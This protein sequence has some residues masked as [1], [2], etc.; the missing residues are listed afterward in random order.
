[1]TWGSIKSRVLQTLL[2]PILLVQGNMVRKQA[3]QLPEAKG[4]RRGFCGSGEDLSIIFLGDSSACGVG[5]DHLDDA[6][7]GSLLDL[8]KDEYSC[9]WSIL[10]KSKIITRDLIKII[11]N[12]A[13]IKIDVAVVCIG[14][15]D[16]TAGKHAESWMLELSEL[17]SLLTEKFAAK[18][19]IFSGIPPVRHLKQIPQPLHYVLSLK[20]SVFENALQEFCIS[21]ANCRYVDID[22]PINEYTM[23]K[24]GF[25]PNKVFY[26]TWAGRIRALL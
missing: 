17:R 6:L 9:N 10:A 18:K 21:Q 11:Q 2:L 16:I 22:L 3:I 14:T 13:E 15:N 20:A 12:E 26:S 7:S 25:H 24:D 23:A 5:V 1:M 8:I 4:A 19:I